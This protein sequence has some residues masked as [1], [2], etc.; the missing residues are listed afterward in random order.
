MYLCRRGDLNGS[1]E[2]MPEHKTMQGESKSWSAILW[3]CQSD[4]CF[5]TILLMQRS[6]DL[7][8]FYCCSVP[9]DATHNRCSAAQLLVLEAQMMWS[10]VQEGVLD[11]WDLSRYQIQFRISWLK[12]FWIWDIIYVW[13]KWNFSLF[14]VIISARICLEQIHEYKAPSWYIQG[15]KK[16]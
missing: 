5:A 15:D 7:L 9:P 10:D 16:M 1:H 12:N 8:N 2:P 6:P 13:K 11:I 3:Q 14:E 4:I